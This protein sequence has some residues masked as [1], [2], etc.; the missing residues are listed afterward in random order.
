MSA[1]AFVTTQHQ[2]PLLVCEKHSQGLR[3]F[4]WIKGASDGALVHDYAAQVELL[5]DQTQFQLLNCK[6]ARLHIFMN[7]F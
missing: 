3:A 2:Q 4:L 7:H 6:S 5:K 1:A